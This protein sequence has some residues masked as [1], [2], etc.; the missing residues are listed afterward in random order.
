MHCFV[1]TNARVH[2]LY[3]GIS[4]SLWRWLWAKYCASMT[5]NPTISGRNLASEQLHGCTLFVRMIAY[6]WNGVGCDTLSHG[7]VIPELA[8][9]WWVRKKERIVY[10][11]TW[12][13]S[14]ES[15]KPL[16]IQSRKESICS[17]EVSSKSSV[18]QLDI[19]SWK[20]V[21]EQQL[22]D[23]SI[24]VLQTVCFSLPQIAHVFNFVGRMTPV[25]KANS[26]T[27]VFG[28]H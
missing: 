26:Y 5:S 6:L 15:L 27:S 4:Y 11:I 12:N 23:Q 1:Q 18:Q 22:R 9:S 20:C 19:C 13:N 14:N 3:K 16:C 10:T 17:F 21:D 25:R 24:Q 2:T 28:K 7:N 8:R